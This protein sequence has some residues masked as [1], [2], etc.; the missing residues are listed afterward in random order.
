MGRYL[1][2][3]KKT[4]ILN[5]SKIK[6]TLRS[7]LFTISTRF[8]NNNN[9]DY[10]TNG[11][12]SF[13]NEL[14]SFLAGPLTLFDVGGN[15]GEYSKILI[16]KATNKRINYSL[17]IFEPT[18]SCF[19]LLKEKYGSNNNVYLNNVGVSN[20]S[21]EA[22][23]YY[24]S[25]KS[26]FASLYQRDHSI[27]NVALDKKE[28]ISLIRLEEYI[29]KNHIDKIDFMKIDIEGHEISAFIGMG[30]YLNSDFIKVIQFEYGGV[31]VDSKTTLRDSY[32]V[33]ESAGFIICKIMK[34]GIEVRPYK[35]QMENYQYANYVA[36]SN[37]IFP[38]L[39]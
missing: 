4:M 32:K 15:I 10:Y 31:N 3:S 20:S 7:I 23:I 14:F 9:A 8:D 12:E 36:I 2:E 35:I 1:C 6:S 28:M 19:T 38:L 21:E 37:K 5:Q 34:R 26:G 24:D 30:K 25:E 27:H 17:H 18:R 22:Y 39:K 29:E 33:L 13:L 16:T 11:E